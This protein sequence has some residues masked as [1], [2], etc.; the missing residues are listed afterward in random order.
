M[1]AAQCGLATSYHSISHPSLPEYIAATS[2]L[3]LGQLTPFLTDCQPAPGCNSTAN[4]VFH[5]A[6]RWKSYAESMPSNCGMT[7]SGTYAP[8]H[9]PAV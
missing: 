6:G 3:P 2:G 7:N 4:N 9:N 1:R 8:R 5:Q